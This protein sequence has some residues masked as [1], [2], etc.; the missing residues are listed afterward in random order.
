MAR[1]RCVH[2]AVLSVF[3][4][5]VGMISAFASVLALVGAVR[6]GT[7]IWDGKCPFSPTGITQERIEQSSLQVPSTRSP[8]S[9]T[10]INVSVTKVGLRLR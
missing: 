9:R 7:T 6:G 8:R 10:L 3:Q 5:I 1:T 4:N 2:S